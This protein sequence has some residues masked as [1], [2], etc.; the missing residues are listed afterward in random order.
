MKRF[1]LSA[2]VVASLIAPAPVSADEGMWLYNEPPR[3][4]LK[5]RY[6][7]EPTREWLEHLQKSSV[8]VNSGGSASFVSSRG[9][10]MT[11]HHVASDQLAKLSSKGNDLLEKGFY[12]RTPE[13]E[14]K[15]PDVELNV[16]MTVEDVTARVRGVVKPSL[17]SAAAEKARRAE[18]NAIEKEAAD[19]TGLRTEVVELYQ[20]A[21]YHLYLYEKYT[22]VRLVFAPEQA[23]AFFGGDTDNFEFPR[24]DLDVTFFRA[25]RDGKPVNPKHF[26]K[27]SANG[28]KDG[29][30]V[31][32]SGHP[33]GTDRLNTMADLEYQRDVRIPRLLDL[34]RRWEV[35]YATYGQRSAEHER[36][37][38]DL[39]FSMQNGRKAYLGRLGGLQ[40]PAFMAAKQAQ[41]DALR[42]ATA[43]DPAVVEAFANVE[44][45]IDRS[46]E[47]LQ[48][49]WLFERHWAFNSD[50]FALA[51][52]LARYRTEVSK[53]NAERLRDF[54]EA[55]LPSLEH[56]L[57]STAPIY[58]DFEI[59]RLTDSLSLLLETRGVDDPL[60]RQI[61]AGK[62]PRE[63]ATELVR[64]TKLADIAERKR[65]AKE[66]VEGSTDPM[67]Q[68]AVLVDP[69]ARAARKIYDEEVAEQLSQSYA[70]IERA[71]F[72]KLGS[73]VPPDATFTLRLSYGTV[74]GYQENGQ[75][76]APFTTFAGLYE[77]AAEFEN[78]PPFELPES[79]VKAKSKLNLATPMNF[80]STC[81][82]IGGNSGSPTVNRA[83]EV[84]GLIFD[85][86]LQSLVLNYA[87]SDTQARATS[88][89]SRAITE[90]LRT[91]YGAGSL[92]DELG[93]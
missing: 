5:E 60:V 76:V 79:W 78:V 66:G 90:A 74:K 7:F 53:P 84:V 49:M 68:L 54:G 10:V 80:V 11:N 15:C 1:I 57:Y 22:D 88:V 46:I 27:W 19:K 48:D 39:L 72:E 4:Q 3:A 55:N 14:L 50:L 26:L 34:L 40:D 91:V 67:I 8:R 59:A 33:G 82:I 17:D 24:Y 45:A 51:Q 77:R 21:A 70:T 62:S 81:D 2:L 69:T 18:I 42:A 64:G 13:Q 92:A 47:V 86:N 56:T 28:S 20:G 65:L 85:G 32:V 29:E 38:K 93:Q 41:E 30:L 52:T 61:M 16:L 12:A 44:R 35:S 25:Y 6:G 9:L 37:S 75:Q 87:Y 83:G 36:Q 73:R 43:D 89:D 63:R 31:F 58:P 23:I 71:R